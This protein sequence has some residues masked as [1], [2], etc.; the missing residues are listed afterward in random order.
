[1]PAQPAERPTGTATILFTDLVASTTLARRSSARNA[2]RRAGRRTIA[3]SPTPSRAITARC[4]K[5]SATAS[6]R[7]SPARPTPWPQRSR[8]SRRS[9][10]ASRRA[11]VAGVAVRDRHQRGRRRLGGCPPARHAARRGGAALCGGRGRPDPRR[12][13]RAGPRRAGAG[14]HTFTPIGPVALKGLPEPVVTCAVAWE[15]RE[16]VGF[17]LPPRLGDPLAVR[18][19]RPG[20]ETEA[21]ALAWAKA[22]DGQRQVVL[23]AGEPGIGKT[24]LATEAARAAHADGGTVLFGACDEDVGPAV[25]ALRRGAAALR[26]ARARR[27]AGGARANP[28]RRARPPRA[29]ARPGAWPSCRRRRWP[30]RRP[31]GSSCSR[32]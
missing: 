2:P 27:R 24:R 29:R 9:T 1:M 21:L 13:D 31:S 8:S 32:R 4:T 18:D 30:R 14:G 12:R 19:V 11:D 23:I 7:R 25:P 20:A 22:R 28:S 15:P 6:W 10:A 26:R 17:P 16:D 3:S 5:T